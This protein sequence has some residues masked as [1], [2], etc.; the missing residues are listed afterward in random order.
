MSTSIIGSLLGLFAAS[1]VLIMAA[2]YR[3]L[4]PMTISA[5]VIR[6]TRGSIP[7][8][9][10]LVHVENKSGTLASL[11]ELLSPNSEWISRLGN[12]D[13]LMERLQKAGKTSGDRNADLSRFRWEQITWAALGLVA[14]VAIGMWSISRGS[15]PLILGIT[16]FLGIGLGFLMHDRHISGLGKKRVQ[17]IDA[18]FPD[19]AELLAFSVTAGETSLAALTRIAYLGNGDLAHELKTCVAEIKA[20]CSFTDALVAMSERTGSRSVERFVSGLVIALERGTP[21]SGVLRAQAA[22]TRNEQRQQLIEL[23]GKKDVVML[24]PVVFFILPTVIVI[25]LFPAMRGLEVLVP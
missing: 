12:A 25:A 10:V 13:K 15:N 22:D 14:G 16:M 19:L 11:R 4:T 24:V 18:Q 3:A 5:R 8:L 2:R 17:R 21:L 7:Q 20:G 9:N 23:A 6:S 1:G